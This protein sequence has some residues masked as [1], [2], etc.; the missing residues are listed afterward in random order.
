MSLVKKVQ[1]APFTQPR[2]TL[3]ALLW[4]G[5]A[6]RLYRLGAQSLWYDET[7]SAFLSKQTVPELIVH[8]ARDIHPPVYYLLLH[9]WTNLAGHSEFALAFLSLLLGVVLIPLTYRLA[10]YLINRPVAIWTAML[11]TISPYHLWYAQEVRMYTLAAALGV[12]SAYFGWRSLAAMTD[13]SQAAGLG[14]AFLWAGYLLAAAVGLYTLYY[15]AFLLII[16]NL[17]FLVYTLGPQLKRRALAALLIVN[18]L[19]VIAYLPWLPIAWRQ[20]TNPPV[21]PWR[22]FSGLDFGPMLLESWTALSLGQSVTPATVW[23][24]L[25]LSLALTGAG[26]LYLR[27][28]PVLP[29]APLP[30][31]ST[32]FFLVAYTFGPLLLIYLVSFLTPLYHVRYV[33]TYSV[34]FYILLGAGLARLNRRF[35]FGAAS[36][37]LVVLLLASLYSIYQFHTNPRYRADDF[38]AAVNFIEERWQPG[39]VI[40]V[41]AGY[42]YTAFDTYNNLPQ[43]ERRRLVP[44]RRPADPDHPLLLQ[45]GTINGRPELG[46]G[47]PQA[48]FYP[49]SEAETAAALNQ[50]ATDFARL[51][52]LR[53]YDTVTDPDSF[54]RDWLA[55]NTIPL[56]DAP[57]AGESNIRVQG[58]LLNGATPQ[59]GD[60]IEFEDGMAL[61]GWELPNRT[62]Q[63]GQ[64]IHLKLWWQATAPPGV[65]Y[66]MSLKLWTPAGELAAQSRDE[67]P[68]GNLYRAT[69]W[70]VGQAV[71]HPV[72][73][74][75]PADLPPGQYWL[76][77]ELYHPDTLQPLARLDGHDPV[78]TL[79]VVN[80]Q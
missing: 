64:T 24:V 26:W 68:V 70:P 48:D 15:F 45:T 50:L 20:A 36:L 65:D 69:A 43:L 8:T 72:Q 74:T 49:L 62:W 25:L 18:G 27:R 4:L 57:F 44:Y 56:E 71:Y 7:V 66:K 29:G 53:A 39:D 58:F 12:L 32:A 10:R 80:V 54:I 2:L 46:W 41:N 75:L 60:I 52:L 47:D 51:W 35:G 63:P 6:L 16:L 34:T 14:A 1:I 77:V 21:P 28:Q 37:A 3:L 30:P 79:G 33:F 76:N 61:T 9:Y 17:L 59:V 67:W 78:V 13:P 38:R 5:F 11:I 42:V 22:N 19:L 73:L 55:Q 40:L 31:L 23:P